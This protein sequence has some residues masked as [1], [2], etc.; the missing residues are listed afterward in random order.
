MLNRDFFKILIKIIGIILLIKVVLETTPMLIFYSSMEI[1]EYVSAILVALIC[2]IILFWIIRNPNII[3]NIFRLDKDLENDKIEVNA[4]NE[5]NILNIAVIITGG[6]MIA[7]NISKSILLLYILFVGASSY[8][9]PNHMGTT[10]KVE[11]WIPLI[12]LILGC[13]FI[14]WRRNIVNYFEEK[15][16]S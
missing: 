9:F 4:L 12:N 13:I 11:M 1:G 16:K 14:I 5:K 3:I 6:L 15:D 2:I 7:N 10:E 8:I